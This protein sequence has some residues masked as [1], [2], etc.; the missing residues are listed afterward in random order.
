ML[1]QEEDIKKLA[2]QY[3]DARS[4]FFIG[5]VRAAGVARGPP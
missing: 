2:A 4:M 1:E 3:A 5:R